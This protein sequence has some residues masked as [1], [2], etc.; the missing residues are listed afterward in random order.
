MSHSKLYRDQPVEQANRKP[1]RAAYACFTQEDYIAARD[2]YHTRYVKLVSEIGPWNST[3]FASLNN[4]IIALIKLCEYEEAEQQCRH[5]LALM[6]E[7]E[8][9][10]SSCFL[11][12]QC[13]LAAS[14]YLSGKLVA[15]EEL[16]TRINSRKH[17]GNALFRDYFDVLSLVR[18][19]SKDCLVFRESAPKPSVLYPVTDY[20]DQLEGERPKKTLFRSGLKLLRRLSSLRKHRESIGTA[21]DTVAGAERR[22]FLIM[23]ALHPATAM[24]DF[25]FEKQPTRSKLTLEPLEELPGSPNP[26]DETAVAAQAQGESTAASLV[27]GASALSLASLDAD[28]LD[29]AHVSHVA[30]ASDVVGVDPTVD[31]GEA[32]KLDHLAHAGD[33]VQSTDEVM[34]W[35]NQQKLDPPIPDEPSSPHQNPNVL[36]AAIGY[37]FRSM[38]TTTSSV[39]SPESHPNYVLTVSLPRSK[40]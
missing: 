3:T 4:Y 18:L 14:F 26:D 25:E 17:L 13:N 40:D 22:S 23:K 39:S 16:F 5:I 38:E 20:V 31:A 12:L 36:D 10:D 1:R 35:L 7:V 11:C 37:T 2:C 6:T 9:H 8:V 33:V 21:G 30:D 19:S 34:K 32:G 15:A 24:F 27:P 29:V 28:V